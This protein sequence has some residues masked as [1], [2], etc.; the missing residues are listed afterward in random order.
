[1]KIISVNVSVHFSAGTLGLVL[2]ELS[3]RE[4]LY[5]SK[6]FSILFFSNFEDFLLI[7]FLPLCQCFYKYLNLSLQFICI[8]R[9]C[10]EKMHASNDHFIY[11]LFLAVLG[12]HCCVGFPLQWLLFLWS[13][14]F[15]VCGLQG[16]QLP[17]SRAQAEQLP[18]TSLVAPRHVGSSW[19]RDGTCVSWTGRRVLYHQAT[20]EALCF[21]LQI[22]YQQFLN[23]LWLVLG[24]PGGSEVKASACNVGDPGLIPGSGRSPGEENGSPL[25]YSCLQNPMDRGV[26][27][28]IVHGATKSQT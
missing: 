7:R 12:P 3:S 1:M 4:P 17:C 16:L 8:I 28:A 26:W 24:F 11:L 20:R 14:G 10:L 5:Y 25:Q 15:R 9:T 19:T 13:T 2:M 18:C 22:R 23:T 21:L 27:R 6:C